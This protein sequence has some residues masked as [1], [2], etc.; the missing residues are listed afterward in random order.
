MK[1]NC[2]EL[3]FDEIIKLIEAVVNQVPVKTILPKTIV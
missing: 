1:K 2:I 3:N